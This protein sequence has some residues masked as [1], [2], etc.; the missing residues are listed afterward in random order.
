[1]PGLDTYQEKA[2]L[3]S[4]HTVQSEQEDYYKNIH[5]NP[6]RLSE[7]Q[8][9]PTDKSFCLL[10]S[11]DY[12]W[13]LVVE[14]QRQQYKVAMNLFKRERKLMPWRDQK[15]SLLTDLKEMEISEWPEKML[16]NGKFNKPDSPIREHKKITRRKM[17]KVYKQN[18][19]PK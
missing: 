11:K 4:I 2:H 14:M 15:K 9:Q 5:S 10:L 8:S 3:S 12:K 13:P 1:M 16:N 7:P 19:K 6:E 18:Q 17:E